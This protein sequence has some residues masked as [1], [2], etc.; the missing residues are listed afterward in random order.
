MILTYGERGISHKILAENVEIDRKVLRKYTKKLI[1]A[2]LV[3]R[4]GKNGKYFPTNVSKSWIYVSADILCKRFR[5]MAFPSLR[6]EE[7]YLSTPIGQR[8]FSY[9]KPEPLK[10]VLS[11]YIVPRKLTEKIDEIDLERILFDFSNTI[12]GFITYALIQS[13]SLSPEITERSDDF[14]EKG[15]LAQK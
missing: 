5:D 9:D 3:R 2:H 7:E 1:E 11:E 6:K 10:E 15:F 13:L 4:E 14:E 8:K 12:G